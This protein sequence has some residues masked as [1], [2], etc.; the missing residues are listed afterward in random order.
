MEFV[1]DVIA[2]LVFAS[3]GALLYLTGE[4]LRFAL[5]L[6][7]R[8]VRWWDAQDDDVRWPSILLGLAFW[9]AIG[10]ALTLAFAR[11]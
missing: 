2:E 8:R 7:D 10:G 9:A 4:L 11:L 6:G 3:L 1:F 5:T